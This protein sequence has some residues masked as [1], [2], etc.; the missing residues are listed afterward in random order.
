MGRDSTVDVRAEA[1]PRFTMKEEILDTGRL[2]A[3]ISKHGPDRRIC[4][5]K[6]E[7]E[8]IAFDE[9]QGHLSNLFKGRLFRIHVGEWIEECVAV[10]VSTHAVEKELYFVKFLRHVPGHVTKVP[11]PVSI[12]GLWGCPGYH[13]GG[14]VDLA[15]P[16]IDC[17]VVGEKVPP[18]FIVDVSS[19]QLEAPYGKITLEDLK[20]ALPKDGTVRFSRDY[21]LEE[22]VVMCYDPKSVPEVPLPPEWKDPNFEHRGGRYHLTYTGFFPKQTT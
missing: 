21:T 4:L 15:M 20:P 17:E 18:P 13:K 1:W 9:P 22:E 8:A 7:I 5:N 6:A 3:V 12:A 16:T 14:H 11:V 19:L 2:P 10:D